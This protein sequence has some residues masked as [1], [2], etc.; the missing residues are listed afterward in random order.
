MAGKH[1]KAVPE[2]MA[3]MITILRASQDFEDPAWLTYDLAF[4]R[5]AAATKNQQWSRLNPTLY[6]VC[7]AGKARKHTRC[8]LC[9]STK[10]AT[11]ECASLAEVDPDMGSRLKAIESVILAMSGFSSPGTSS[12][13]NYSRQLRGPAQ[14]CQLFNRKR[15]WYKQCRFRHVCSVCGGEKPAVECCRRPGQ[16]NKAPG[17][18]LLSGKWPPILG[19]A[20]NPPWFTAPGYSALT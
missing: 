3:Y 18:P 9:L 5:Q 17:Q 11:K 6:N 8:E 16:F 14:V 4:R 13:G 12:S 20:W 19:S 10:H 2:L 7:T 15:C 1:P